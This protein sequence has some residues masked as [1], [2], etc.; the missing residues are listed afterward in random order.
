LAFV[1][2]SHATPL[3]SGRISTWSSEPTTPAS[4]NNKAFSFLYGNLMKINLKKY[5]QRRGVEEV[6][7][8]GRAAFSQVYG[9]KLELSWGIS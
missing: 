2:R 9:L 3:L 5:K 8:R 4:S 6:W 7:G 1:F